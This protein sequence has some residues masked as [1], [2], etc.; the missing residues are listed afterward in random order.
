MRIAFIGG[1]NMAQ[2]IIAGVRAKL[3]H[4]IVIDV[5]DHHAQKREKLEKLYA[6]RTFTQPAAW[7]SGADLIVLAVKPQGMKETC[8]ELAAYISPDSCVLSIAA[9]LSAATIGAWLQ[10]DPVVRAMPNTPAMVGAGFTGLFA[11][12]ETTDN[13]R[14]LIETIMNSVGQTVWLNKEE[15]INTVIGGPGSGPAY[16]FLF[17]QSLAAALEEHG[18]P[19][20]VAR[21]MALSTVEGAAKLAR[22]TGEDFAILRSNVTSKGG[23]TA[24]ALAVFEER[25]L[26]QTVRAAVDA[27]IERAQEMAKTLQ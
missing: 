19:K 25:Q 3:S 12:K 26:Q 18:A 5:C 14:Q 1:G 8:W 23:T 24:A 15:E 2:A 6:V 7:L 13:Q 17:M 27:C 16:V 22:Q 21:E 4:D 10:R 11:P 9:G 20:A